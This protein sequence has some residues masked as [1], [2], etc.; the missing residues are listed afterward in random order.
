MC[1]LRSTLLLMVFFKTVLA[2]TLCDLSSLPMNSIG[3]IG[4]KCVVVLGLL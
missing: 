3:F 2:Y 1:E 4:Q